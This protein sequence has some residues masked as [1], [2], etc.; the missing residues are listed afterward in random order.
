VPIKIPIYRGGPGD[1]FFCD[2]ERVVAVHTC[3][4]GRVSVQP[5][6][7]LDPQTAQGENVRRCWNLW[8]P[9]NLGDT[10]SGALKI[11]Y[12]SGQMYNLESGRSALQTKIRIALRGLH[13]V[14]EP[15]GTG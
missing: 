13:L 12:H 5:S 14:K 8:L 7:V 6:V 4:V 1:F 15:K 10:P 9:C 11:G 2:S 3:V